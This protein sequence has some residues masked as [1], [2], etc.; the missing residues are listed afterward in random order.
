MP[1][2]GRF[3][4]AVSYTE[5]DQAEI[6]TRFRRDGVISEAVSGLLTLGAPGGLFVS[7]SAGEAMV[8]GFWYKNDASKNIAVAANTS[9]STRIDRV[10][11]RLQRVLN[12]ITAVLVQGVAGGGLPAITQVAGGDWDY[13][14]GTI[15]VPTGTTS[16][17]T[18]AML[19]DTRTYSYA[20]S[21]QDSN[22]EVAVDG[23]PS[24][25]YKHLAMDTR[26]KRLYWAEVAPLSKNYIENSTMLINQYGAVNG[27]KVA[28]RWLG[29]NNA[30]GYSGQWN[31][32]GPTY[33]VSGYSGQRCAVLVCGTVPSIVS[34]YYAFISHNIEGYDWAELYGK[35]LVAS[36]WAYSSKAST[37]SFSL[38]SINVADRAFIH[39]FTMTGGVW[40][41]FY[42][43]IPPVS[44]GTWGFTNNTGAYLSWAA[45]AGTSWMTPTADAWV[46]ADVRAHNTQSN[47]L[48]SVNDSMWI[49]LPK[50]EVGTFPTRFSTQSYDD[51][52][53]NCLRMLVV[54]GGAILS[55]SFGSTGYSTVDGSYGA[56]YTATTG[57]VHVSFPYP[58]RITPSVTSLGNW[59][60]WPSNNTAYGISAFAPNNGSVK[61]FTMNITIAGA[62]PNLPGYMQA[63][64]DVNARLMFSAE[65]S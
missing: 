64:N 6:Q 65:L 11:L 59:A 29:I 45:A 3:F 14:L 25:R 46:N 39:P 2:V 61:E 51:E 23:Q 28:D 63:N 57:M 22:G 49:T 60:L 48:T 13:P 9:G 24:S 20:L 4:D 55:G 15:T 33:D 19:S 62:T 43:A 50:L 32:S 58:M 42:V 16:A 37:A 38:R 47:N 44:G 27:S 12:A 40:E 8:Q 26:S 35:P 30:P 41:Y 52:L 1:E 21:S 10:V 56:T 7:V 54:Y 18:A 53:R 31:I 5:A 34:G 36:W 17:V